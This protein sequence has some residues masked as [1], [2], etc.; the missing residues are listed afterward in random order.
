MIR[1]FTVGIFA[2]LVLSLFMVLFLGVYSVSAEEHRFRDER[3]TQENRVEDREQI[4]GDRIRDGRS[5]DSDIIEPANHD[6]GIPNINLPKSPHF[7]L[8]IEMLRERI[9]EFMQRIFPGRIQVQ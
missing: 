3:P 9:H 5:G 6:E 7:P 1:K 4:A 8:V 2:V